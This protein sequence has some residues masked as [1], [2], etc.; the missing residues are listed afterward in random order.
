[1]G[2]TK[3]RILILRTSFRK[4]II[5]IWKKT[6][7]LIF[8]IIEEGRTKSLIRLILPTPKPL[9]TKTR[10][11]QTANST[12]TQ[13]KTKKDPYRTWLTWTPVWDSTFLLTTALGAA[14][15]LLHQTTQLTLLEL[16]LMTR[17]RRKKN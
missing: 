8:R 9:A 3:R 12:T 7:M 15:T 2:V 4:C 5:R 11:L 6:E 10:K 14:V 1:M 17:V 13:Q 16:C